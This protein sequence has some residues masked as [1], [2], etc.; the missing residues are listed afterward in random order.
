[1][2]PGIILF[3]LQL[4]FL[5]NLALSIF[6]WKKY[7]SPF[8]RPFAATQFMVSMWVL[9][10]ILDLFSDDLSQKIF[11][12]Q[13]RYA[14]VPLVPLLWYFCL[15]RFSAPIGMPQPDFPVKWAIVPVITIVISL[16]S[17]LH[18]LMHSGFHI[19][20]W[21]GLKLLRFHS[22]PWFSFHIL[23]LQVLLFMGL[24]RLF[25]N[26]RIPFDPG[27][28]H[29]QRSLVLAFLTFIP[30]PETILFGL[31]I[32][33]IPNHSM[34][35]FLFSL[36]GLAEWYALFHYRLMDITPVARERV[37]KDL[38]EAVL[39]FDDFDRLIDFN[40]NAARM[41]TF[42]P[43]TATGASAD[44][45]FPQTEFSNW[46][47][48][49]SP[50]R[51]I[52]QINN[53]T[54][55]RF[56][57]GSLSIIESEENEIYGKAVILS[58]ITARSLVEIELRESESRSRALLEV[59]PF[60]LLIVDQ[61]KDQI[62]FGNPPLFDWIKLGEDSVVGQSPASFYADSSQRGKILETL[63]NE[64]QLDG[65]EAEFIRGDGKRLTALLYVR[66]IKFNQRNCICVSIVDITQ[67]LEM[68]KVLHQAEASA[69]D[70]LIAEAEQKRIGRDL[71][72]NLGQML[73]GLAFQASSIREILQT[74]G[75][76]EGAMATRLEDGLRN[77]IT[78]TR[79]LSHDL[80]PFEADG[81]A[82]IGAL[83]ELIEHLRESTGISIALDVPS[84]WLPPKIGMGM[85]LLRIIQEAVQNAIKHGRASKIRVSLT[86]DDK[87]GLLIVESNGARFIKNSLPGSGKGIGIM[88]ARAAA[89]GGQIQI[90]CGT[91]D[92]TVVK[93]LFA[94]ED[95]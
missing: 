25:R 12:H 43:E 52:F 13:L 11:F 48:S 2:A 62:V 77:A 27:N 24:W 42:D 72:D 55:V 39:V 78:H 81:K 79:S 5:I 59:S 50:S 20:N 37:F 86:V 29:F 33:I 90:S 58:D 82:F 61:E 28:R 66:R 83:F 21:N 31:K 30:I 80:N 46:V 35:P 63:S 8:A 74:R 84:Q 7:H 76:A 22:G 65:M 94:C 73:T 64:G 51:H 19:E 34:H 88:N 26:A 67:R 89:F 4:S 69:R 36:T 16:T 49:G 95:K 41:L 18:S 47:K 45:I 71:H 40:Q 44:S 1:M 53:G 32:T 70:L 85:H 91:D 56:L 93:C 54:Q 14:V 87:Q 60:P 9:F 23:Y 10:Y 15:L 38:S 57:E 92:G 6:V 68:E 3:I 17:H 75:L